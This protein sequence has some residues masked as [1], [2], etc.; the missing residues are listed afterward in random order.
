MSYVGSSWSLAGWDSQLRHLAGGR[1][2]IGE[3][4]VVMHRHLAAAPLESPGKSPASRAAARRRTARA[5]SGRAPLPQRA[6]PAP[7]YCRRAPNHLAGRL[8]DQPAQVQVTP[9]AG[10]DRGSGGVASPR[11]RRPS[12]WGSSSGPVEK[13]QGRAVHPR[14]TSGAVSGESFR[15]AA[16]SS[17][18]TQP[19]ITLLHHRAAS[20]QKYPPCQD[21]PT[22]EKTEL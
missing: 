22:W 18:H 14:G 21:A 8:D 1:F 16:S 6:S 17:L 2:G 3:G 19:M 9:S 11:S 5:G 10:P 4:S 7:L 20:P 15:V 13:A 12:V